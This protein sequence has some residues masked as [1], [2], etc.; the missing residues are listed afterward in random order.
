MNRLG[1]TRYIMRTRH[2]KPATFGQPTFAFHP[3]A[4]VFDLVETFIQTIGIYHQAVAGEHRRTKQIGAAHRK[5][6]KPKITRH[7]VKYAFK[8]MPHIHR[9]VATHC[10]TGWLIGVNPIAIILNVG[11]VIDP[12]KQRPSIKDRHKAIARIGATAHY[13]FAINGCD[14]AGFGQAQ[15]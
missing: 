9:A 12:L 10:T 15:L 13:D 11:D 8:R 4:G 2:A 6:I 14:L 3:F 5:R 7:T 1:R